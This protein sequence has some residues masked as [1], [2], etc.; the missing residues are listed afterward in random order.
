MQQVILKE[1]PK[2]DITVSIVWVNVLK[3]DGMDAARR[4][5]DDMTA[6]PRI[7]HF[8]DPSN[9]SGQA[10]SRR[11]G[12]KWVTAWDIYL[13]YEK[14]ADWQADPPPPTHWMHQLS[15]LFWDAHLRT[16]DELVGE[17]RATMRKLAAQAESAR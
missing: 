6:D 1:F 17:L 2:A 10:I 11:L 16:G 5:A 14:E 15:Y 12:W 4:A 9:R 8:Y 3:G 7:R 13:F